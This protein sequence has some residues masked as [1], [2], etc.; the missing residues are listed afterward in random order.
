MAV[1]ALLITAFMSYTGGIRFLSETSQLRN[2]AD[3]IALKATRLVTLVATSNCTIQTYEKLPSSIGNLQ[4]W[5]RLKNSSSQAWVE[6]GFGDIPSVESDVKA[7]LPQNACASGFYA[8]GYGALTLV[9]NI[10]D[11]A[12]NIRMDSLHE[13][14]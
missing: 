4:Y 3:T 14:D 11:G 10:E 7:Y 6:A 13:A 12:V 9:S 8:A 5:L 1:S 2:I